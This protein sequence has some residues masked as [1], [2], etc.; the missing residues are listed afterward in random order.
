METTETTEPGARRVII[1]RHRRLMV[2]GV[3]GDSPPPLRRPWT[4]RGP[5]GVPGRPGRL[6]VER[7][8]RWRAVVPGAGGEVRADGGRHGAGTCADTPA[9]AADG[10]ASRER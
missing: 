8:R 7:R 6:S 5:P 2:S 1:F 3:D 4:E 10:A 9:A